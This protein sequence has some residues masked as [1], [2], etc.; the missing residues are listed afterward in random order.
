MTIECK[1]CGGIHTVRKNRYYCPKVFGGW[2]TVLPK[3]FK[4]LT[5][6]TLKELTQHEPQRMSYETYVF[7]RTLLEEYMEKWEGKFRSACLFIPS[8]ATKS[9]NLSGIERAHRIFMT[10]HMKLDKMKEEL[11]MAAAATY[12]DHPNADMRKYWGL[13]E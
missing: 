13:K 12:K 2:A 10:E 11:H 9:G 7:L 1:H 8:E 5:S 3:P 6:Q 4:K